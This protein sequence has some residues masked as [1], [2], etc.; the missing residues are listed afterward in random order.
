MPLS[1]R[2]VQIE[3]DLG[4]GAK[5][6]WR[7]GSGCIVAGRTVLTAG[8]VVVGAQQLT[9]KDGYRLA[10]PAS[11]RLLGPRDGP[12]LAL[13]EI[14]DPE[15]LGMDPDGLSAMP[16]ARVDRDS[17]T[18]QEVTHCHAVGFPAFTLTK[19]TSGKPRRDS[20]DAIGTVPVLSSLGRGLLSL[21]VMQ[22]PRPLPD[23]KY[24][25]GQS[26]WSG[27]SGG[28]VVVDGMLLGVVDEHAPREGPSAITAVPLTA[29]EADPTHDAW[30]H[31]V[32]DPLEW[33]VRLGA[34]GLTDL[35]IVPRPT[36][37]QHELPPAAPGLIDFAQERARHTAVIGREPVFEKLHTWLE[38][39]SQGWILVKGSPGTGKSAILSV[40]LD[41]LEAASGTESVPHHFIRRGQ[42]NWDEPDTVVRNLSARLERICGS[43]G[44]A[45]E[46][47]LDGLYGLLAEAARQQPDGHRLVIVIDGLDE[48]ALSPGESLGRFL[49]ASLPEGVF[50]LCASRPSYPQLGWLE[51]RPGLHVMDLDEA[52]W[53]EQN[54]Q[55]VKAYWRQR[56]PLFAPP[57]NDESITAAADAAQ[58]NILHAVMLAEVFAAD[59]T[60]RDTRQ[61]P[62]GF[63]AL[64]EGMWLRL[65][66]LDEEMSLRVLN[67]LGLLAVAGQAL[68]LSI[69]ARLLGWRH[70]AYLAK[71]KQYALPFLLEEDERW[72]GGEARYRPFHESTRSFLTSGDRMSS[73]LRR[74]WH[75][76]LAEEL[77]TW[78]PAEDA[79][80]F[81]REYA[82]RWALLHSAQAQ[83]WMRVNA[84]LADLSHGIA[85]LE[86]LGPQ[87]M[88]ARLADIPVTDEPVGLTERANVLARTLRHE[89]QWLESHPRE[90]PSLLHNRL[91]CIGWE[92]DRIRQH[93]SGLG[94]GWGL[95]QA[96]DVGDELAILRG[97]T[98]MV[99]SCDVDALARWGVSGGWDGTLRVWDLERGTA[100]LVIAVDPQSGRCDIESCAITPDGH[101]VASAFKAVGPGPS[102]NVRVRAWRVEDGRSLLDIPFPPDEDTPRVGFADNETLVVCRTSGDVEVHHL[103]QGTK[104]SLPPG[105]PSVGDMDID[106]NGVLLATTTDVGCSVRRLSDGSEVCTVPLESDNP[107]LCSFSPDGRHVAVV[108]RG[109]AVVAQVADGSIHFR[110]AGL[111]DGV[112][113]CCLLDERRVMF[114]SEWG[115][116][117]VVWDMKLDRALVRYGGHTYTVDCCAVTRDGGHALSGGGDNTV[118]LWSL[119]GRVQTIRPDRHAKLVYGCTVDAD[120]KFA[121]SAPQDER[122]AVWD[123]RTGTRLMAL[124]TDVSYGFVQFCD[125]GGA[126]RIAT[127]GRVLR[128]FDAETATRV[129]EAEVPVRDKYGEVSFLTS[130]RDAGRR[131]G[132]ATSSRSHLPLLYARTHVILWERSGLRPVDLGGEPR[133][134]SRFDEERALA[135]LQDGSLK[136]LDLD[137]V[138]QSESV[139]SGVLGCVGSP[140]RFELYA[141][142]DDHSVRLLDASTGATL[143]VLGEVEHAD[144]FLLIDPDESAVW[145]VRRP[146]DW[147]TS[148]KDRERQDLT[149]FALD[150]SGA[151][152]RAEMTG[153]QVFG[154]CFLS[155]QLVTAG[156]DATLRIWDP[157]GALPCATIAGASPFRC[158]DAAKDRIVAGDQRG[159][160]WFLAPMA[161]LYT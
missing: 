22:Q 61:I 41:R 63:E 78:P 93:F 160:L 57:L 135:V 8:H 133:V 116:E 157:H 144:V 70:P 87:L 77:A 29:L 139:A 114:T 156:W 118:R 107:I 43:L 126:Q 142:M 99:R 130:G 110:A 53:S 155:G 88:R 65:L 48:A 91:T 92:R 81:V 111:G 42:G 86:A 35:T 40:M 30:G 67:G 100:R 134:V 119:D 59:P 58:G 10:S 136:V 31:G 75:E 102:M 44:T 15:A 4:A 161:T 127:L 131:G 123:A 101:R 28:P 19:S 71:F 26:Q 98:S 66:D 121:C 84:L 36:D 137:G 25:L 46:G 122:P 37:R 104:H 132:A 154:T 20:V 138:G 145:A 6:Q 7:Y 90:F 24:T 109:S 3:A 38:E 27:M 150:G 159:N 106:P 64:L 68:P 73:D 32:T 129:W 120:A 125:F 141:L 124:P 76:L 148:W 153:H 14:D 18:A 1:A 140:S 16:L 89:G 23:E 147:S 143:Q 11:L 82:A 69:V 94:S 47:G 54:R 17:A 74:H 158:V 128:V 56:G 97:H 9:V 39:A 34:T 96:V 50:V 95:V 115:C 72:H 45:S 33:W 13:I 60:M 62:V 117:L 113:D 52:P 79:T 2:V 85:A 151:V 83:D 51:Q 12:D 146:T 49:P 21:L 5:P 105:S 80:S 108:T 152:R 112:S 103:D 149:V 55:L